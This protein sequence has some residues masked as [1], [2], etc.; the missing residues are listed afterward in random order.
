[1]RKAFMVLLIVLTLVGCIPT[2]F[3]AGAA[4]SAV[5]YD[6]RSTKTMIDDRQITFS[7]QH[8]LDFDQRFIEQAH[9]SVA[10]FNQI[11]LLLG[12]VRD[13]NL[14]N[15]A[16]AV[17][18]AHPKVRV[19]YNEITVENPISNLAKT[20]D[21]WITAKVKAI[22]LTTLALNS[23]NLKVVTEN[24]VVYLMGLTTRTQAKVAAENA[25]TIAGVKKVVKLME[26][27]N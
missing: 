19:V 17:A 16:E 2:M 14:R 20:N 10:T 26:Y 22:F 4:S 25:S 27:L 5:I 13:E 12:Q 11:V 1:M 15:K 18:K 23:S 24:K 7:I 3:V 9:L 6:N 8:E 21:A